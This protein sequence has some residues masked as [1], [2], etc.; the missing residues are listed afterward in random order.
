M[1]SPGRISP[2]RKKTPSPPAPT[3]ESTCPRITAEPSCPGVGPSSYH[4]GSD[5][6]GP[7]S[8]ASSMAPL[9]SRP[10]AGPKA[11][12][13]DSAGMSML[14]G[15]ERAS[16]APRSPAPTGAVTAIGELIDATAVDVFTGA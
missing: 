8:G 5:Q 9:E 3:A 12:D 14:T 7:E 2:R 16:G 11:E 13:T 10:R 4:Q 6:V 15:A 1:Y